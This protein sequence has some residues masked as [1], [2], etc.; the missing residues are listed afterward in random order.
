MSKS[1]TVGPVFVILEGGNDFLPDRSGLL[2]CRV[3]HPAL[4]AALR[5]NFL[6][7]S[8]GFL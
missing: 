8:T 3:F 6:K 7:I 1:L 4:A 5:P 2:D